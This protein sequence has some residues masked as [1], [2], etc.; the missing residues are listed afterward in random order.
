MEKFKNIKVP[1]GKEKEFG[2]SNVTGATH[3]EK[4]GHARGQPVDDLRLSRGTYS[5]IQQLLPTLLNTTI[6]T[7]NNNNDFPAA[8]RLLGAWVGAADTS[9]RRMPSVLPEQR[10]SRHRLNRSCLRSSILRPWDT[11]KLRFYRGSKVFAGGLPEDPV[12]P[13]R[14]TQPDPRLQAPRS[15]RDSEKKLCL[16]ILLP[17]LNLA[18]HLPHKQ[19]PPPLVTVKDLKL[20]SIGA[21]A[22]RKISPM[23]NDKL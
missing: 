18:P 21:F 4:V 1:R 16:Q 3:E 9:R 23:G 15:P 11:Y 8:Y 13:K 12:G 10:E 2:V 19:N 17:R 22:S 7:T 6:T 5:T 20:H 14:Y